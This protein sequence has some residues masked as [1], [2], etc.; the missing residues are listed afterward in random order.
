VTQMKKV[1]NLIKILNLGKK[2]ERRIQEGL[3]LE[4]EMAL[5]LCRN[6][7]GRVRNVDAMDKRE[8]TKH[9]FETAKNGFKKRG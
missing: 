4:K 7:V 2:N 5:V 1:K 3:L 6:G 8:E 9:P